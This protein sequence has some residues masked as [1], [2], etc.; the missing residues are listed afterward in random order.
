MNEEKTIFQKIIDGEIP[1]Y[2]IYEDDKCLVIL[3]KFPESKGKT[4]VISKQVVDYV[5]DLDD[6]TYNHMFSVAK[7][8]IKATDKALGPKRTCLVVE[9]FEVPHSHIKIFPVY[10]EKLVISGGPEIEESEAKEIAQ[11]IRENL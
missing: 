11:K 6:E 7:K 4:L 1:S 9:G 3:D 10:D 2:K 8:V 5:F